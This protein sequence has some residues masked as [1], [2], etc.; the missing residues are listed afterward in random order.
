M[1]IEY[2]FNSHGKH[3]ANSQ[4]GALY[5]TAGHNIGH[6]LKKEQVYIDL[7]GSYL[8]ELFEDNRLVFNELSQYCKLAFGSHGNIGSIGSQGNPGGIGSTL[9]PSN[10]RDIEASKMS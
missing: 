5:S 4:R 8:G 9:L 6:Y 3:I 2:L 7:N 10:L 1:P